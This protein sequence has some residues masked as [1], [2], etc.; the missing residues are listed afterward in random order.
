MLSPGPAD[1][2]RSWSAPPWL[3]TGRGEVGAGPLEP[4]SCP[5]ASAWLLSAGPRTARP[6]GVCWLGLRLCALRLWAGLENHVE[7]ALTQGPH[8]T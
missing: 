7:R 5:Q 3:H 8:E 4:L 6:E 2:Q 1:H